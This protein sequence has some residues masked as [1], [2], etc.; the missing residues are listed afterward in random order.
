VISAIY[1]IA[2]SPGIIEQE[3]KAQHHLVTIFVPI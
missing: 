1:L 3:P 2:E